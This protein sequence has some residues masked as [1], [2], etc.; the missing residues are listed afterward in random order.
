MAAGLWDTHTHL[1][2]ESF[3]GDLEEV[4]ARARGRGVERMVLVGVDEGDFARI[5]A[6]LARLVGSVAALGIYPLRLCGDDARADPA[7]AAARLAEAAAEA[8]RRLRPAAIGEIGL[9]AAAGSEEAQAR[10]FRSQLALARELDVPALFHCRR[11]FGELVGILRRDGLPR[12]GAIYHAFSGSRE[13]AEELMALGVRLGLGGALTYGNAARLRALVAGLPLAALVVETDCPDLAPEPHRGERNEPAYLAEI[14]AA[15]C[16]LRAE[17]E[18]A[19]AEALARTCE[20]M[21]EAAH[22]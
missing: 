12:R 4:A 14:F 3:A 7:A 15:L 9:D 21:F 6:V 17:G 10:L 8:A 16:R 1:Q 19:V 13:M 20:A 2:D 11:R 22:G 5:P 18:D